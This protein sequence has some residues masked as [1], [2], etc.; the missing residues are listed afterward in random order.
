VGDDALCRPI[1]L[2]TA[3]K[4]VRQADVVII[5]T[6]V[7]SEDTENTDRFYEELLVQR[8]TTLRVDAVLKGNGVA[9]IV[10]L[11][12]FR[13]KTRHELKLREDK[14]TGAINGPHLITF[15]EEAAV[16]RADE[17]GRNEEG[18]RPFGERARRR[19]LLFLRRREGDMYDPV[20]G[21]TEAIFSVNEIKQLGD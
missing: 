3:E 4:L 2:W 15:P 20:S 1:Q 5:G 11:I 7:S 9:P 21:Q 18:L 19:Y 13:N 16:R 17:Q 6:V 12:H 10:T 8:A 14:L